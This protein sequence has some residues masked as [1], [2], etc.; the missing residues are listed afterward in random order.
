[1]KEGNG[2][3]PQMELESFKGFTLVN[4]IEELIVL[5]KYVSGNEDLP[6]RKGL[7]KSSSDTSVIDMPKQIYKK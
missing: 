7:K 3:P 1:M 4:I 6:K 2:L 5:P